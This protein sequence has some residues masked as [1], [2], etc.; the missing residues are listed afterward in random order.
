M[1]LW[2]RP[3]KED[4]DSLFVEGKWDNG[5]SK[6]YVQEKILEATD[7]EGSPL[8]QLLEGSN[9]KKVHKS[10]TETTVPDLPDDLE[11]DIPV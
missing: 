9:K 6:N 2:D 10:V 11:D 3:T 7:F 4:W 5:D 1:F 8:H